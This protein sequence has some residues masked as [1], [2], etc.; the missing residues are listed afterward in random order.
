MYHLNQASLVI[1]YKRIIQYRAIYTK[2]YED[3]M[4]TKNRI[5]LTRV[6]L[7]GTMLFWLFFFA[8]GAQNLSPASAQEGE[9]S[10]PTPEVVVP[11]TATPTS[12][13]EAQ[14]VGGAPADPGEYP[15]QVELNMANSYLCGGSLVH[16][17][18]V[19]TAAHCV[20]DTYGNVYAPGVIDVY[21][22]EYLRDY[23]YT[24]GSQYRSVI[25]VIRHPAYNSYTFD[26]D[27]ALIKLSSPV[28][29]GDG[30]NPPDTKTAVI[31]LVPAAI[32]S[33]A[34]TNAWATGW[35]RTS[36]GGSTSSELREVQLPIISNS[37]C[38]ARY[39]GTITGNMLCAG[40]DAGGK[41]TC[42]GDSGGPLIVWNATSLQYELAGITSFVPAFGCAVS[43]YP[44]GFTRV[45]QFGSWVNNYILDPAVLTYPTQSLDIGTDYDP[46][47][48]WEKATDITYYHLY[49]SGPK[50]VVIDQ[51]YDASLIC[52]AT[53]CSVTPGP[54]AT[55]GGG[56]YTW[57]VQTWNPVGSGPWT[58]ATTFTTTVPTPPAMATN[59]SPNTAIGT[60]Y[61]PNYTWD[62]MAGATYYHLVVSGTSGSVLDQ[63]YPSASICPAA[64]CSVP[65]PT[66]GGGT[67]TWY[68][69]TYNSAGYGPWTAATTFSTTIPT[70]PAAAVNL[71]PNSAIGTNY[72][73][74][75]TWD[76]VAT[77]A[78]YHLVVNGPSSVVLDQWY[79]SASICP[80]ST[81]TV[82]SPTL[83]GG[84]HVWKVQT[85]NPAGFGPWSA[86]TNFSTTIPTAPGQA[87][88]LLPN[89]AI[90]T[91]YTPNYTWD[92]V[93]GAAYYHLVVS[94][95]GGAV[96]DKWYESSTICPTATC[97]VASP[98][99]GGGTFTWYVQTWNT[100]G[101]GPWSAT[102]TF[103]TTI[104]TAPAAAT[105]LSPN[106]A[107]GTNYTPNYT[108]DKVT[109]ATYYHLYVG[110]PS[111]K[112]LDQW[113]DA[114]T[115][116]PTSTCTVASPTLGGGSFTWYVQ[117][118]NT[119][120]F[121][122]WTAA[123]TFS[124]T[125]P[126]APGQAINL[127]PNTAIGSNYTP[128]YT[129]D[130]VTSAVWYHLVVTSP[131]GT[132]LDQW[133]QAS[134]ICPTATCTVASPT[135]GG[136][137]YVWYV[138]TWNSAG[139]GPW[140]AATAFST[141]IPPVPGAATNLLPNSAIGTNYNPNYTWD[142][143]TAATWYH[144]VV[145]GPSGSVL[146]QWYQASV[147]CPTSTCTVASPTLGGGTFT[148]YVQ[149]YNSTGYGPWTAAT[150]FSTTI[151]TAPAAA[152]LTAPI[153]TISSLTPTYTW[154]KVPMASWYHIYVKGPGGL[155]KDQ[156]YAVASI[157]DTTTCTVPSPTLESGNHIWWVQ[158]Y[159]SVGYGLW[160]S[161]TFTVSP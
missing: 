97:T 66:L 49:V 108:W 134:I 68:V 137:N 64:T 17:Q 56:I 161:A 79:T 51:W 99:L 114:A 160:K 109:G 156:W 5:S 138:Q 36:T 43:Y 129:W 105:N 71:S 133:Y 93:T 73:P 113:Y 155:V 85:W 72:N 152:N 45:S 154:D 88:N 22:G 110:G 102:T 121:G 61:N 18:W 89:T 111:G 15:W 98:A 123:T 153:G 65:S 151:P 117:T 23:P 60:N 86:T 103:S 37:V 90:G 31:P 124:T 128:N 29:I 159:N 12:E 118:W 95:P 131:G 34:G 115:I 20:T 24:P 136:G 46:I 11:E 101:F 144:L 59:L 77:A 70:P 100:A 141:T 94:G 62:K 42:F 33:L 69:Q 9:P 78:Y 122:P 130:K 1:Y 44:P 143:V 2:Y 38:N 53:T 91:N 30:T 7:Y 67:F 139:Y 147:I 40:Y 74:N 84:A 28:I 55:L 145:S 3:D 52:D 13:V 125:I 83:G 76:K 39:G 158:A 142:K 132:V 150:T 75:Y 6:V 81:C 19:L 57:Y 82:A 58:A 96:L 140:S 157:C 92:K 149:T 104:P 120:G 14:I 148:W 10:T 80:T 119:A 26:S 25:Q 48:Q 50:G 16:P 106:S 35:G 27:I 54:S 32:G 127:L 87:A 8:F 116:C 112:V 47:Y 146:D 4:Q 126:T 41:S 135:L 63:W 107:I 21:A